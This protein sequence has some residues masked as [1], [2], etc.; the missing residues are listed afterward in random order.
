MLSTLKP[1]LYVQLSPECLTVR[2]PKSGDFISEVPELAM[3]HAPSQRIVATGSQARLHVAQPN[4]T[5]SNPFAHPRTLVSDFSGGE[6]VLKAF[7]ARLQKKSLFSFAPIVVLH[8]LGH[9]DGGFT[10]IEIRALHEM[11]LG[12]GASQVIMWSGRSLT[13]QEALSLEFP[14]EGKRLE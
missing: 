11:A 8:P 7:F 2:N 3:Q 6:Q 4:T 14:A 1:T 10:Q 12:A 9:P 13:D 5:V